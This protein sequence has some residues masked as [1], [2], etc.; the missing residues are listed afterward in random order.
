M[1]RSASMRRTTSVTPPVAAM[2]MDLAAL[3]FTFVTADFF[4]DGSGRHHG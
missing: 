1:E 4:K 2:L 3:D